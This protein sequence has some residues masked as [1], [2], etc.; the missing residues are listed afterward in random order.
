MT[1]EMANKTNDLD[2]STRS[3]ATIVNKTTFQVLRSVN[4]PDY[5]TSQ[6]LINPAG[7][8]ALEAAS[9]PSMYWKLTAG[10]DDVEEMT[11]GEKTVVDDSAEYLDAEKDRRL[12]EI[13]ART[14]ELVEQGFEY[15][16]DSGNFFALDVGARENWSGL[17]QADDRGLLPFP[18]TVGTKDFDDYVISD[19]TALAN[20]Y[21]TA[22]GTVKAHRESG[23]ALRKQVRDATTRAAV[24]AVVDSR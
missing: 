5:P 24:D 11:A 20:F 18:Q 1:P 2:R 12:E 17:V 10:G 21:A 3:M 23:Q 16:A 6:W 7:L 4:T 15:P 9:V 14:E 22:L 13:N 19:S 8:S